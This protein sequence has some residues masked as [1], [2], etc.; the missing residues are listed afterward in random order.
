MGVFLCMLILAGCSFG[1]SGASPVPTVQ[2][3]EQS[4]PCLD[5][6]QNLA[7]ESLTLAELRDTLLLK[8]M[9]GELRVPEAE[10]NEKEVT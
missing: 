6:V 10:V 7:A 3:D 4:A 5:A 9:S 2:A 1:R 8:L